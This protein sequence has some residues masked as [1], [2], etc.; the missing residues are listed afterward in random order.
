MNIAELVGQ[1]RHSMQFTPLD[2]LADAWLK[3]GED[4]RAMAAQMFD[5][6]DSFI[7]A[8]NNPEE[9]RSLDQ[10][11]AEDAERHSGFQ[12]MCKIGHV[13]QESLS[14]PFFDTAKIGP[15][16]RKYGLF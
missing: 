10:L 11:R 12:R 9:R 8:M 16:T 2:I 7:S 13:F 4:E 3:F 6:Y 14:A 15:L 1:M 5:S